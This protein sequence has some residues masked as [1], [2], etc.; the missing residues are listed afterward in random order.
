MR[1]NAEVSVI[2]CWHSADDPK[3]PIRLVAQ[4]VLTSMEMRKFFAIFAILLL[5]YRR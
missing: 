5:S 4:V 3:L 1:S 2:R